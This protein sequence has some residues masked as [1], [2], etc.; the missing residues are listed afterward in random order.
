M[1]NTYTQIYIQMVFAVKARR[2][3]IPKHRKEELHKYIT[4]RTYGAQLI[5]L[6]YFYK[7]VALTGLVQDYDSNKC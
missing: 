4:G 6:Y 2:S 5:F 7:K 3:L 1:A